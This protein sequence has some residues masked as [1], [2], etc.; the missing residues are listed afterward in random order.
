MWKD[1]RRG[2]PPPSVFVHCNEGINRALALVSLL[3]LPVVF[4]RFHY[5]YLNCLLGRVKLLTNIIWFDIA[6]DH[7]A[8]VQIR[9]SI[10]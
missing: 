8:S 5:Y 1:A 2:E 3:L 10:N 4:V 7:G 9:K 6:M